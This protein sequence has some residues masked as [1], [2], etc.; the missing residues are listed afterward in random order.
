MFD[1]A[2]HTQPMDSLSLVVE[3]K[4]SDMGLGSM[5]RSSQKEY[6]GY[7]KWKVFVM[8][9]VLLLALESVEEKKGMLVKENGHVSRFWKDNLWCIFTP[10]STVS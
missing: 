5:D 9:V 8:F 3:R 1:A 7:G 10:V 4:P 6:G 2:R